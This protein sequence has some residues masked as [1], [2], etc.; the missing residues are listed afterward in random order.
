[1][2]SLSQDVNESNDNYNNTYHVLVVQKEE[3]EHYHVLENINRVF[4]ISDLHTDHLENLEWLR[5]KQQQQSRHPIKKTTMNLNPDSDLIIVAGDI[6]HQYGRF[7]ETLTVLRQCGQVLFVPGNHEAWLNK[8]DKHHS[9]H[10]PHDNEHQQQAHKQGSNKKLLATA[11]INITT[12]TT[13]LDKLNRIYALCHEHDVYTKPLLI[14]GRHPVWIL[15]LQSWY[16]GTLSFAEEHCQDF[17]HWPWVDFMRCEWPLP[18]F[19][20]ASSSTKYDQGHKNNGRIPLGLTEYFLQQNEDYLQHIRPLIHHQQQQAMPY[21]NKNNGSGCATTTNKNVPAPV[22]IITVS[23]FLPNLQSLPDW[24][25]LSATAFNVDEW[26]DHGGPGVSAKFSK[27]AGSV[28]IDEQIRS[29]MSLLDDNVVATSNSAG[30]SASSSNAGHDAAIAGSVSKSTLSG[31]DGGSSSS[32]IHVF[33]HSHRPKD[34]TF[35]G[36]R[37]IHNPLG[38]PKERLTHT[39]SPD[40]DFQLLWENSSADDDDNDNDDSSDGGGGGE[41]A[42]TTLLRYWEECAGGK[43]ALWKRFDAMNPGRYQRMEQRKRSKRGEKKQLKSKET[44]K[45]D[46]PTSSS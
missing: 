11:T 46:T 22:S 40:V 34:F 25:D 16:D 24:K 33:G 20:L 45:H 28:L 29:I 15:P 30:T 26:L 5:E 17:N 13:S 44:S 3:H 2:R 9:H 37:Y 8:H 7:S 38:K 31:S 35:H 18:Q 1:M 19:P 43:E 12:T 41:V 36:I 42:G 21:N 27:V 23:H 10:P 14:T 32:R 6:S 4:C 39:V